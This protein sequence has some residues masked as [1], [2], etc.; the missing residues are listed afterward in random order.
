MKPGN[1]ERRPPRRMFAMVP[2]G[3]AAP[4]GWFVVVVV[5]AALL[6]PAKAEP[7][8]ATFPERTASS[9]SSDPTSVE[10]STRWI[11]MALKSG[12]SP[13]LLRTI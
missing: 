8:Q 5:V 7:A 2:R 6:V 3:E 4:Q 10:R 1:R 12:N 13:T 11:R 9:P